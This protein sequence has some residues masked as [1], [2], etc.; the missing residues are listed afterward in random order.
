MSAT[1]RVLPFGRNRAVQPYVGGGIGFIN[2]R[3]SETGDFINFTLPGRP[4]FRDSYVATERRSGRSPSSASRVPAGRVTVGGEIR[5]Q[6]AEGDLDER[7]FLGPRSISAASTTSGR[8]G[9]GSDVVRDQGSGLRDQ[10]SGVES[11]AIPD[12]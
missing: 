4:I 5:Y 8:S 12:P 2:W 1:V 3:Y 7:D 6:K 9:S 10:S 11:F